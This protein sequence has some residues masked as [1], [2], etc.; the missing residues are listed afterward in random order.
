MIIEL[1]FGDSFS[2]GKKF[3][4]KAK[5]LFELGQ[6]K[7]KEFSASIMYNGKEFDLEVSKAGIGK[8]A[9]IKAWGGQYGYGTIH[10]H[11][12]PTIRGTISRDDLISFAKMKKQITG[13][14]DK[15]TAVALFKTERTLPHQNVVALL[16]LSKINEIKKFNLKTIP[17]FRA[18]IL[19][20]ILYSGMKLYIGRDFNDMRIVKKIEDFGD[21]KII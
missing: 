9:S 8:E 6:A 18:G 17:K 12:S 20:T 15:E 14:I 19:G 4:E 5:E 3:A 10:V 2:F 16:S 7:K 21:A 1:K 11:P 13:M